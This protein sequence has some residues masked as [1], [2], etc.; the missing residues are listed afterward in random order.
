MSRLKYK[1]YFSTKLSRMDVE[2]W[3]I[4][5]TRGRWQLEAESQSDDMARV[6]YRASFT[7]AADKAACDREFTP[8]AA[9][10]GLGMWMRLRGLFAA[11]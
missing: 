4:R 8:I 2:G 11:R 7:D 5:N 1:S 9:N 6:T 3:I 10:T